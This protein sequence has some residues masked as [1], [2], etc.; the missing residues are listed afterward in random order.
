MQV[1][2]TGEKKALY[3]L[4]IIFE[5][6]AREKAGQ[7]TLLVFDDI[8]D[9]FDYKNKYAIIQYMKDIAEEPH[10]CQMILTHNFDYFR[11][12]NSRFVQY[13]HCLMASRSA[14]GITLAQAAG[15][16][17][18]FANDWRPNYFTDA[19][20]RIASIPFMRNLIEYTAGTT[21]NR[22]ATLT[23]LLHWK[24]GSADITQADVDA[25]Y[26]SLFG[27]G[28]PSDDGDAKVVDLVHEEAGKCLHAGDGINLENKIVLSMAIRLAAE[29]HMVETIADDA[30]VAAIAAN[31]TPTLLTKYR[32]VAGGNGSIDILQRVILMTPE[33]IHLNSFMYEPIL[34][35]SDEHLRKLYED[36]LTLK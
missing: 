34:D 7:E 3:V 17:N 18:V 27:P 14:T 11:T 5:V 29:R 2:S 13:S 36:V 12:I 15:I 16:R 32:E 8:A 35:M 1:L 26:N 23:S 31:Q 20:K 33:N 19:R 6:E 21:D 9:S 25:I 4:N 30:F 24:P 10:F 22:Y 28:G